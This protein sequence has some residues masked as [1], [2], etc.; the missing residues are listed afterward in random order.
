MPVGGRLKRGVSH[1]ICLGDRAA[2]WVWLVDPTPWADF[3][4]TTP[5]DQGAGHRLVPELAFLPGP[6]HEGEGG[7]TG[8]RLML[9]DAAFADADWL[10]G[11][12]DFTA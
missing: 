1:T 11:L 4:F 5:G 9:P 12:P 2:G 7:L 3:E 8:T 10:A 6:E